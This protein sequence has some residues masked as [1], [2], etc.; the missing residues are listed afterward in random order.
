MFF[1]SLLNFQINYWFAWSKIFTLLRFL[2]IVISVLS[3]IFIHLLKVV[4]EKRGVNNVI[5]N[6][7]KRS[8]SKSLANFAAEENIGGSRI[9]LGESIISFLI[10]F[11]INRMKFIYCECQITPYP[12]RCD[13]TKTFSWKHK[14]ISKSKEPPPPVVRFV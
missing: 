5:Q 3:I 9:E 11:Q 12:L 14:G 7:E 1:I 8:A 10:D 6:A 13:L 2:S 4:F